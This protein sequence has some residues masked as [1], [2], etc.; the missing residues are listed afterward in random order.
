MN[1]PNYQGKAVVS[2]QDVM[3]MIRDNNLYRAMKDTTMTVPLPRFGTEGRSE[4]AEREFKNMFSG[5]HYADE[6]NCTMTMN[7][8]LDRFKTFVELNNLDLDTASTFFARLLRGEAAD[9]YE[10]RHRYKGQKLDQIWKLFQV[11][12]RDTIA[13]ENANDEIKRII[14]TA[15]YEN[16][17]RALFRIAELAFQANAH[18]PITERVKAG[19]LQARTEVLKFLQSN[20]SAATYD[21]I[22]QKYNDVIQ[23]SSAPD[24]EDT[25]DQ[26][27]HIASSVI[28]YVPMKNAKKKK[29]EAT[30]HIESVN[31][32][33][34]Q[35]NNRPQKS[36]S[37]N[38]APKNP[39]CFNCNME[40]NEKS[41]FNHSKWQD[42]PFYRDDQNQ[43]IRPDLNKPPCG[44]CGG[45][46]VPRCQKEMRKNKRLNNQGGN[47]RNYRF[48][49]KVEYRCN[50]FPR[51]TNQPQQQQQPQLTGGNAAPVGNGNVK[52]LGYQTQQ[53]QQGQ[54]FQNQ[55]CH[56]VYDHACHQGQNQNFQ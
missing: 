42:C 24:L 23:G 26:L 53:I 30:Y 36:K 18:L 32:A 16:G 13:P 7:T 54:Q 10:L 12:W 3:R 56:Q 11:V 19:T 28:A 9:A 46:H 52:A 50:C 17:G 15:P 22:V 8:L 43:P 40:P 48:G 37:V 1:N 14:E 51:N 45:F 39:R 21:S 4:S 20:Y 27:I 31:N 6:T 5:V 33:Q 41:R 38:N 49:P 34:Q 55:A 25:V 29:V 47:Q 35:A 44:T 2:E